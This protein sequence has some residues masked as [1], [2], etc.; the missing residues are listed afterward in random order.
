MI[1]FNDPCTELHPCSGSSDI[2]ILRGFKVF[3]RLMFGDR[4]SYN[5]IES[6]A[7]VVPSARVVLSFRIGDL[8]ASFFLARLLP[9]ILSMRW[10]T[11]SRRKG[12]RRKQQGSTDPAVAFESFFFYDVPRLWFPS[13]HTTLLLKPYFLIMS[14]TPMIE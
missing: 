1:A 6:A 14:G 9:F 3:Q 13:L 4:I 12:A 11:S 10:D 5:I 2:V 8:L 7:I